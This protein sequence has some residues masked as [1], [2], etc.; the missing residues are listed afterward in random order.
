MASILYDLRQKLLSPDSRLDL[1]FRT[2]YHRINASKLAF[3]FQDWRARRSYR[4]PS[5]NVAEVVGDG[6]VSGEIVT[7]LLMATAETVQAVALTLRSLLEIEGDVW[8][9]LVFLAPAVNSEEIISKIGIDQRIVFCDPDSMGFSASAGE[10]LVFCQPGDLFFKPLVRLF[11]Q[12]QR[13]HPDQLLYYYDCEY[14]NEAKRE[15]LPLLKPAHITVDSLLSVNLF[16]RGFI[17]KEIVVAAY[18]GTCADL[19]F[20]LCEYTLAFSVAE[21]P[22]KISHIPEVLALQAGLSQPRQLLMVKSVAQ[23]LAECGLQDV[24]YREDFHQPHFSWAIKNLR[25]AIVVPTKNHH[26]LL[27]SLF[28]SLASTQYE[29]YAIYLVDNASTDPETH[30]FYRQVSER[31]EVNVIPYNEP[32]NYSRAINLGAAESESDLLLF[33]NDDVQ[34]VRPEWLGELVQWAQ[35]PEIGVVSTKLIRANRTIHHAGIVVGLNE[36]VGHIYLNAPEHYEG[37]F[38]PVDWYRNYQ[39]LTGACQMVRRSVFEA[40]QGYDEDFRLAFGDI[41]FCL[42]VQALGYRN[43]YTPFANL[44]HFEGRSRGYATPVHDI[45]KGYQ[46]LSSYLVAPDPYYSE[47]LTLTR[48]PRYLAQPVSQEERKNLIEERRRFYLK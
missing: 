12:F 24:T 18:P 10:Y 36:F 46:Q 3:L 48:I 44:Y 40:V 23:Y 21:T 19:D 6:E 15:V 14:F 4:G 37:L 31:Q 41:D 39:A 17:R 35:R 9:A 32:F 26:R 47:H 2:V 45:Q 13:E 29:N 33:L 11:Y 38:G 28:D 1:F 16:S 7:F 42:K 27:K 34:V 43:V 25:V 30:A 5:K 8:Q 20:E 22:D